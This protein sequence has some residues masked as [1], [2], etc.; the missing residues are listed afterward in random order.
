MADAPES[1]SKPKRR[2]KA[3][4]VTVRERAEQQAKK[5]EDKARKKHRVLKQPTAIKPEVKERRDKRLAPVRKVFRPVRWLGRH[6]IPGYFKSAFRELRLTTWP[7]R[8][9]S[10]QFTTA[11][12]IFAV[13]FGAFVSLLDYGLN[14]LFKEI[15]VK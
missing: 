3:P 7:D 2:I 9:Q 4:P 14:A 15:I 10:R 13:I 1:K 6:I 8:R 5:S 12:I 11:V